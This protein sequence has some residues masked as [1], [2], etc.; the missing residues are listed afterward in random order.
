MTAKQKTKEGR[1][2]ANKHVFGK[3][4]EVYEAMPEDGAPIH[5]SE[6]AKKLYPMSHSTLSAALGHGQQIG[7]IFCEY[8]SK[9]NILYYKKTQKNTNGLLETKESLLEKVGGLSFNNKNDVEKGELIISHS[10]DITI[11]EAII[12]LIR[13]KETDTL[14]LVQALAF[15]KTLLRIESCVFNPIM[16]GMY[17]GGYDDFP[18]EQ[19]NKHR[20]ELFNNIQFVLVPLLKRLY[21]SVS[22]LGIHPLAYQAILLSEHRSLE[23]EDFRINELPNEVIA[24]LPDKA[25][26][27]Y[28]KRRA[29]YLESLE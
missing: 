5:F 26:E 6:L 22:D 2:P 8:I 20:E 4:N 9:K 25:R 13:K 24:Q 15:K 28:F 18:K 19:I 1:P 29:N 21:E 11:R 10:S 14:I 27:S 3:F 23:K 16:G 12:E 17:C 7:L